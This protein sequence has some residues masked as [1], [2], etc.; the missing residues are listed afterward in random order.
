MLV[1][2]Y[3]DKVEIVYSYQLSTSFL[4]ANLL[5]RVGSSGGENKQK[6][7]EVREVG[8]HPSPGLSGMQ[9]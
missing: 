7:K 4:V 5:P 8:G 3:Y 9:A 6:K 2:R 1:R